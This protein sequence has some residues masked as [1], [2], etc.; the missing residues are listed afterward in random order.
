MEKFQFLEKELSWLSFNHRV[1][2][3]AQDSS[4]PLLERLRFLGIYSSNMDEFYRVRVANVRRQVLF[5]A[6]H[7]KKQHSWALFNAIQNKVIAL[8]REFDESYIILLRELSQNNIHLINEKQLSPEQAD[9]LTHYY[10]TKLRRHIF[11]LII[12]DKINLTD[13]IN[14]DCTY[15]MVEMSQGKD[16]Q[17]AFV[18]VPSNNV[19][20]FVQ[21]PDSATKS[22]KNIILL[23]N[24]IRHS[25]SEIFAGFFEFDTI[26]AYSMKLTRDGELDLKQ[27]FTQSL[28][29]LMH[30]SLK[31]RSYAAPV[32]L[33]YD[34]KMPSEM[35]DSLTQCLSIN[36]DQGLIAGGRYHSFKDFI[37]FPAIGEKELEFKKLP[38]IEQQYFSRYKNAFSAIN[39]RDILLYYPYHKF[40]HLTELLRQSAFDPKVQ[41]IEICLYR[42]AKKSRVVS[43]L[44]EAV[45]NGKS[46]KVNIELQARFDEQANLAWAEKLSSAGAEVSYG[47]PGLKVHAKICL[48]TRLEGKKLKRYVHIGTGNF[49]EKNA[50][51][52]TDFSLFTC[53]DEIT[54]EVAN[55]F[56]FIKSPYKKF[57]FKHLVVSPVNSRSSIEQL[58]DQEIAAALNQQPSGIIIKV[59]NLVDRQLIT[60][61]YE[62]NNAGV[63]IKLIVRG[64][65][66]LVTGVVGQ[67]E[68][69]EATSIVGRHLE[70]PRIAI[71]T[72][73]GQPKVYLSSADWM[74]RNIDERIEVGCPILCPE[75][76]E[77][78]IKIINI[79]LQDNTKAR[80][81]NTEQT[82]PYAYQKNGAAICHAQ[83]GIY[84]Y[85][86]E[87]QLQE[88]PNKPHKDIEPSKNKVAS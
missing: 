84:D 65:C 30:N 6:T 71:F 53:H 77:T 8:Q 86:L 76:K 5:A 62:A 80:L 1:L 15:L 18:E 47:V 74:H 11:P 81:L 45:K 14:D 24:I 64:V 13:H 72:N 28:S 20:R 88:V 83:Q 16:K 55:V 79:Q 69:I 31:K 75:V 37:E 25:L 54:Q 52:Y 26:N 32:R 73:L 29:E 60:K 66:S 7:K 21:L 3:E 33:V 49:N 39:H 58:I 85:L 4:V 63:K 61:L 46:V 36:N 68:N 78:I 17:H 38:A 70:H 23:D 43:A 82:N 67:S 44:I 51:I 87:Q 2:Q 59:N 9:W 42:V 19:P 41:S 22:S 35:L 56:E 40:S 10:Q 34:Y 50:K 48:I 57:A 27:E 12:N